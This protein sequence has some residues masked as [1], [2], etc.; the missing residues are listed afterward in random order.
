MIRRPPRSTLFPYTTLFRSHRRLL[1]PPPPT[2]VG[3]R[4]RAPARIPP[5]HPPVA[6]PRDTP[7]PG[8]SA[9]GTHRDRVPR[10]DGPGRPLRD[11]GASQRAP[12]RT[13]IADT[14]PAAP[15]RRRGRP[16]QR[17]P[18]HGR[19]PTED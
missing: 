12:E 6:R 15:F 16:P 8:R 7:P 10:P 14:P 4:S 11:G 17:P 19:A 13:S 3:P 1:G 9:R 5:E 2:G 18:H